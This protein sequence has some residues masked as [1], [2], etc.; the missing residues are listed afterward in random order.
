MY[1]ANVYQDLSSFIANAK[2]RRKN[3]NVKRQI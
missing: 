1:K 2:K 3:R